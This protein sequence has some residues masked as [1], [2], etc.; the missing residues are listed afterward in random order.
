M[1]WKKGRIQFDD[2]SQYLAELLVKSDGQIWNARIY[3]DN[4]VI[5]EVDVEN[6]ARKL[7]KTVDEV[8]PYTYK[9]DD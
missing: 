1:S 5:E 9:I 3:K 6:F 4:G 7:N 8:Y 2:G